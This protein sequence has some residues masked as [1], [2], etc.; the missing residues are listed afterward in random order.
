MAADELAVH[1][2]HTQPAVVQALVLAAREDPAA[3]VR[4]GCVRVLVRMKAATPAVITALQ[5]MKDDQDERVRK[6]VAAALPAL[7]A[8]AAKHTDSAVQPAG[9]RRVGP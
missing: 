6:E 3:T 1:D 4:A 9:L 5:G 7:D 8:I 2:W